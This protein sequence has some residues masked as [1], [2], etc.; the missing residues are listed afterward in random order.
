MERGREGERE[1]GTEGELDSE[2]QRATLGLCV[3]QF[4]HVSSVS[5]SFAPN[6]GA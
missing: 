4:P 1:R 5:L 2:W 3:A 6:L